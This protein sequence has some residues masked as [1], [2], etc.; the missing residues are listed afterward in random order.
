MSGKGGLYVAYL[1]DDA[2]EV[3]AIIHVLR[4][5]GWPLVLAAH[6][7]D[8]DRGREAPGL[9]ASAAGV[10]V[11]WS[12]N[13]AND[14]QVM[15]EAQAA[16]AGAKMIWATL[17]HTPV[18]PMTASPGNPAPSATGQT[19]PAPIALDLSA[20][21]HGATPQ[22]KAA[23]LA[24]VEAR[25][26]RAPR[27]GR[28]PRDLVARKHALVGAGALLAV[29]LISAA[30][31]AAHRLWGSQP[32]ATLQ[33]N[34][35]TTRNDGASS[36]E[37]KSF[38]DK[39]L[40]GALTYWRASFDAAPKGDAEFL[41]RLAD[42][43]RTDALKAS[44]NDQA[45]LA[46]LAQVVDQQLLQLEKATWA[47]VAA[48][49]DAANALEAVAVYRRAFP[50]GRYGAL[51]QA[52]EIRQRVKVKDA[53]DRLAAA[54]FPTRDPPGQPLADTRR[55]I[56]AYE[57]DRGLGATGLIDQ[58]LFAS[59][60]AAKGDLVGSGAQAADRPGS[61]AE[62]TPA[63]PPS[64]LSAPVVPALAAG[65]RFRD[66]FVCPEM[67]VIPAGR[68]Q[69]GDA[70]GRGDPDE[71]PVRW[72]TIAAP[73]AVGRTEV[74]FEEW[75][76]CV[77]D[78]GCAHRPSDMGRGRGSQP[79]VNVSYSDALAFVAWLSRKTG[80]LYRLL[81][82]AE[83]EYAARA[84]ET[85]DYVGGSDLRGLCRFGDGADDSS[86]YSWRNRACTDAF[87][88]RP[89]PAGSLRANAFGLHHMTG[90]GWEW[91]A[92]CWHAT[93]AGAPDSGRA[94]TTGC[95]G[96]NRVLRGGAFSGDAAKLRL[97]DRYSH[98][99]QRMPFFGLRVARAV[100]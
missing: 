5:A 47:K 78:G 39:D 81:S 100:D 22:G 63:P 57:R 55:A 58:R 25:A 44:P 59:L 12:H 94:W 11:C 23:L 88:D 38:P 1:R 15:I 34:L 20:W 42:D 27:P 82:E 51:S 53:Q 86:A 16:V 72:V 45:A 36:R 26:G 65:A 68:F 93:Y 95:D 73:L 70:T 77:T 96:A 91:T 49:G 8:E 60:G 56:L 28:S 84:G 33:A 30:G 2:D 50:A 17:D 29:A 14:P 67:L 52:E 54:G 80:K 18:L 90:N 87:P 19:S 69:M 6:M 74:T 7:S 40:D 76:A 4:E 13:A 46:A 83:W 85:G 10:V 92:D 62:T 97:S 24:A 41:A 3:G 89:A 21:R 75:D 35:A 99:D 98:A 37:R 48:S 66:C 43:I 64:N 31:F 32:M 71:R 79:A 61:G 9:I